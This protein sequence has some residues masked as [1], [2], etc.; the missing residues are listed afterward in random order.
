MVWSQVLGISPS[1]PRSVNWLSPLNLFFDLKLIRDRC[2]VA[3]KYSRHL[4]QAVAYCLGI[5]EVDGQSDYHKE[6]HVDDVVLPLNAVQRNG[7]DEGVKEDGQLCWY[8]SHTKATST[9]GVIP[10]FARVRD[11]EWGERKIIEAVV[12]EEEW[13][14][15]HTGSRFPGLS[16]GPCKRRDEYVW[17]EHA[18]AGSQEERTATQT[19]DAEGCTDSENKVPDLQEAG[20]HGL[21]GDGCNADSLKHRSEVVADNANT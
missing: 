10:D 18:Y 17:D 13:N 2:A 5:E 8:L 9:V 11:D 1:L 12:E 6:N 19:I 4:F 15:S 21:I 7:V 20:D 3:I 14:D 16:E